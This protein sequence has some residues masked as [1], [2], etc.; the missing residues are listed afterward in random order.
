MPAVAAISVAWP[1]LHIV[2]FA[3]GLAWQVSK[4][5]LINRRA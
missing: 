3:D 4:H 2:K 1:C 5:S